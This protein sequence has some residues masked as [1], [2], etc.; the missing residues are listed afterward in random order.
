MAANVNSVILEFKEL[1]GQQAPTHYVPNTTRVYLDPSKNTYTPGNHVYLAP[2]TKVI[3]LNNKSEVE[4]TSTMRVAVQ[5]GTRIFDSRHNG[6]VYTDKGYYAQVIDNSVYASLLP[7]LPK[8]KTLIPKEP[9]KESSDD[10]C[11]SN[12]LSWLFKSNSS[13]NRDIVKIEAK[14]TY[15]VTYS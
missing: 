13:N 4:V 1:E 12:C 10:N 14:V 9:K 3:S 7:S 15:K 11:C 5:L 6:Q 8:Y 2:G